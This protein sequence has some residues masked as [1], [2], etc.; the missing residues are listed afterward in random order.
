MGWMARRREIRELRAQSGDGPLAREYE[1]VQRDLYEVRNSFNSRASWSPADFDG[2]RN[3]VAGLENQ[4]MELRARGVGESRAI[5]GFPWIESNPAIPF[6]SGGPAHPSQVEQGIGGALRLG[7]VYAAARVLADNVASLPLQVYIPDAPGG[8]PRRYTGPTIFN[9]TPDTPPMGQ[10]PSVTGTM[11]DWI[12]ACVSSL[13]LTGN[14]YGYIA[15]RDAYGYPTTIEW[16]QPNLVQ[17]DEGITGGMPNPLRAQYYYEGRLVDKEDMFHIRAFTV[18]GRTEGISPLRHAL[19]PLVAQGRMTQQYGTDWFGNGGFP[20]GVMKNSMQEVSDEQAGEIKS[21][22]VGA[23]RRHQP[24]VIGADWEY[25]P[26]TVP[27]SEAQFVESTRLNAT[28]IAAIY[29]IPPYRIGGTRGDSLTYCADTATEILTTRGWL[30]HDEVAVGD[31]ALTL[32]TETGLAEWQPVDEVSVFPGQHDV[33]E[34]S[35]GTHSSVTTLDHRWPVWYNGENGNIPGYRW[36]T[37]ET[38]PVGGRICAASPVVTPAEPKWSDALVELM[39]WFWTEGWIGAHGQVTITQSG[40]ANPDKVMRIRAALTE[41]LGSDAHLTGKSLLGSR[42]REQRE[43]IR[44]VIA[45]HPDW[46]DRAVA[47]AAGV[48]GGDGHAVATARRRADGPGW[49]EDVSDRGISHFRLNVQAGE[50]LTRHAPAKVVSY[51]W[52]AELTRAQLELF[53]Q[54]SIDADGNWRENGTSATICQKDKARLDSFQVACALAGKSGVVKRASS[55]MWQFC[56]QVTSW[57][58]PAGHPEYI[59]HGQADTVWCPTT[60]NHTWFAR[61]N[62]TTYFT[63]NSNVESEQISFLGETLRPWLVRLETAFYGLLPGNRYCRFNADAMVRTDMKTRHE[64]YQIDRSIGLQTVDEI[65]QIEDM[66]PL[67]RK[68]G[69]DEIPLLISS[70]IA[71]SG[72]AI[73]TIWKDSITVLETPAGATPALPATDTTP[74]PVQG[75]QDGGDPASGPPKPK[76][77]ANGSPDGTVNGAVKTPPTTG[78]GTGRKP[79]SAPAGSGS[80]EYSLHDVALTCAGYRSD[81]PMVVRAYLSSA[82]RQGQLHGLH[83]ASYTEK[84]MDERQYGWLAGFVQAQGEPTVEIVASANGNPAGDM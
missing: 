43:R 60:A 8:A 30:H 20:P 16:F 37:T 57:R 81:D 17:V 67:P 62:G 19:G 77:A 52:L 63:G 46:S 39:G 70:D 6:G 42:G 27:P 32:N 10:G 68:L 53:I 18:P 14:A 78:N 79:V 69:D 7:P 11:Y 47:R 9:S 22:L 49:T 45:E 48:P 51:A 26:I 1:R 74:V 41:I 33:I 59:T 64:I 44:A 23:I 2:Y 65:R 72:K 56:V 25:A 55:G 82:A 12:F 54:T 21:R 75:G 61:R 31:T 4:M 13:V 24:L 28:Q 71:R 40:T 5:G 76:T 66:P 35:N 50:T 3:A 83:F 34:M 73:P 84:S 80:R 29:G 15:T 58:K 38:F 36:R